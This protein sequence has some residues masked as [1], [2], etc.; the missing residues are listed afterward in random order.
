MGHQ[1]GRRAGP[2]YLD[3]AKARN[4]ATVPRARHASS[5]PPE[6]G[7]VAP[8]QTGHRPDG[9]VGPKREVEREP[10]GLVVKDL[11]REELEPGPDPHVDDFPEPPYPLDPFYS[12]DE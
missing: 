8:K 12:H 2:A 1:I 7:M 3:E 6:A 5:S 10:P 11:D 4:V 9:M